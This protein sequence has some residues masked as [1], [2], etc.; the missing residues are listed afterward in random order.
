MTPAVAEYYATMRLSPHAVIFKPNLQVSFGANWRSHKPGEIPGRDG[1]VKSRYWAQHLTTLRGG[2]GQHL[3]NP[4][5]EQ[6][7]PKADEPTIKARPWA[8]SRTTTTVLRPVAMPRMQKEEEQIS[9]D[10]ARAAIAREARDDAIEFAMALRSTGEQSSGEVDEMELDAFI[11]FIRRRIEGHRGGEFGSTGEQEVL[12]EATLQ[13]LRYF[14]SLLDRD[15]NG[16]IS[17]AEFFALAIFESCESAGYEAGITTLLQLYPQL[18][19]QGPVDRQAF[20]ELLLSL[21]FNHSPDRVVDDILK[22]AMECNWKRVADTSSGKLI[23][24]TGEDL[25]AWFRELIRPSVPHRVAHREW[26]SKDVAPPSIRD[27]IH[28]LA[29]GHRVRD[30]QLR[31]AARRRMLEARTQRSS[32]FDVKIGFVLPTEKDKA[33][34]AEIA[35]FIRNDMSDDSVAGLLMKLQEWDQDGDRVLGLKEFFRA[36]CSALEG[37]SV[38]PTP[39]AVQ[40][41]FDEMDG[42]GNGKVEFSE[43]DE[44]FDANKV[45]LRLALRRVRVFANLGEPNIIKLQN[46]MKEKSFQKDE[47]VFA[48]G[49]EGESFYVIVGGACEVLR[50]EVGY[51][52]PIC[53]AKLGTGDFFGERSL[54]KSEVRYAG[55]RATEGKDAQGLE[56]MFITAKD[57]EHA[58]GAPL[59]AMVPD[60]YT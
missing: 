17:T 1:P 20:I 24:A 31:A 23:K 60:E 34:A 55:I 30:R 51:S 39:G 47:W 13:D 9:L 21:G 40:V 11:A 35:R 52:E 36:L 15:G 57:F 5:L 37:T 4:K 14:F 41:L 25:L 42:D 22:Q 44:W 50:T 48:Q 33:D 53:L 43:L 3:K 58:M 27:L 8:L 45:R 19:R 59:S 10:K 26:S 16:S 29:H 7:V 28:L 32:Y 56:T 18:F 49:D 2:E 38:V 12:D 6:E 46:A 54:L